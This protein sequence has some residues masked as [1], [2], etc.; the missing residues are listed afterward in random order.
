MRSPSGSPSES[1]ELISCASSLRFVT[2]VR[3]HGDK[4]SNGKEREEYYSSQIRL[5]SLRVSEYLP[6]EYSFD[7]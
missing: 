4:S 6:S 5:F 2:F 7:R 3:L 1:E